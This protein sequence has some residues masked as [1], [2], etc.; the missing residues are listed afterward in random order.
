MA[1]IRFWLLVSFLVM[2]IPDSQRVAIPPNP[3][4]IHQR[5]AYSVDPI[6]RLVTYPTAFQILHHGIYLL[7]LRYRL[8]L[9][10]DSS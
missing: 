2:G 1:E 3:E 10:P 4:G 8:L 5:P 9:V 6:I 7:I